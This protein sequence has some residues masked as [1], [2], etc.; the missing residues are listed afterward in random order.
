MTTTQQTAWEEYCAHELEILRPIL[1]LRGY[2]IESHQPHLKGERFLQQAVTT[3]SGKK[4]ILLGHNKHGRRVV[5]KATRDRAGRAELQRERTCRQVLNRIDF[6]GDVFHTPQEL[7]FFVEA[8]FSV[9]VHAFIT[10]DCSFLERTTASQFD[11]ALRAFKAQESAHATTYKHQKLIA[12]TYGI[13]D[14]N[15]YLQNF[16]DFMQ[17][18]L[19]IG[20][21]HPELHTVFSHAASVLA[22]EQRTISQYGNFL[23]HTDFVPHNFRI[24]HNTIYLLDHSSLTFGN[25][26][27]GWARF[28]NFMTLYNPQL[29]D[30]FVQYTKDNRAS[31][32]QHSLW[33][34]RIYR[35]GE[36]IWY[37]ADKI[38]RCDGDL[39][40]LNEAR[41]IFW[42]DILT[43]VLHKTP[44]PP[45]RI[46]RYKRTRDQLRSPEEKERQ[47][48]LH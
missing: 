20:V 28:I 45:E 2:T 17:N 15:A 41:V 24:A 47:K 11:F 7:D 46:E 1:A 30:A 39:Q 33:L 27:E 43:H 3:T 19:T 25:K 38:H 16:A 37:Y 35:L 9:S 44:I 12:R 40:K 32:E 36:L 31:E 6:A 13:R 21:Q 42:C 18:V 14:A 5:I 8:G 26:H 34:M 22:R 10:Q 48:D 29:A 4:M 23:T